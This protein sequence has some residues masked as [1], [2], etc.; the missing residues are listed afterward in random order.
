MAKDA[1]GARRC[2]CQSRDGTGGAPTR[3]A[4]DGESGPRYGALGP[5][6]K[7]VPSSTSTLTAASRSY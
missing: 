5:P 2:A 4:P 6:T 1:A 3:A 7:R